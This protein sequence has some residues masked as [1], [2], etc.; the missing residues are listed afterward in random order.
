VDAELLAQLFFR[1]YRIVH[2]DRTYSIVNEGEGNVSPTVARV[3]F[4]SQ[5]RDF[6]ASNT[7]ADSNGRD[8]HKCT[9]RDSIPGWNLGRG[10][11]T[12]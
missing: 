11:D 7:Q 3:A 9:L 4:S 1:F 5:F 6:L 2:C 12:Q 8:L 10:N